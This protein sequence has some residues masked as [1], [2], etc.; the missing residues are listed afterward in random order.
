MQKKYKKVLTGFCL[1]SNHKGA[2][3]SGSLNNFLTSFCLE[4][5]HKGA[6][7]LAAEAAAKV[8]FCLESNHKGAT[9]G[10]TLA[11]YCELIVVKSRKRVTKGEV[12]RVAFPGGVRRWH[13]PH[14]KKSYFPTGYW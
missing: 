12:V 6:T 2:T 4:S 3:I 10:G 14:R 1:E 13:H 7:M 5:N 9:I 8:E 11:I